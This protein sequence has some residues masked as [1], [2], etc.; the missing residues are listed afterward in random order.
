[1][2]RLLAEASAAGDETTQRIAEQMIAEQETKAALRKKSLEEAERREAFLSIERSRLSG[3]SLDDLLQVKTDDWDVRQIV[4]ELVAPQCTTVRE[5]A[6]KVVLSESTVRTYLDQM[7]IAPALLIG[8][9][10]AVGLL[11]GT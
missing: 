9:R 8:T 7:G 1:M 3:M 6:E 4:A 11:G 5:I 2:R 10:L